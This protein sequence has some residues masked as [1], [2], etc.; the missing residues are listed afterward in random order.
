MYEKL[1]ETRNSSNTQLSDLLNLLGVT[2]ATYYR[3]E[4]GCIKFSLEEAKKIADFFGKKVEEIFF[5]NEVEKN[6]TTTR[7][8]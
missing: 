3:K 8:E 4:T 6:A 2:K 5:A 7:G 1:R